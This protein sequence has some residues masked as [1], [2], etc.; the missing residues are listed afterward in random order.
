MLQSIK[1]K[2]EVK[3]ERADIRN[4][5]NE[6]S[7]DRYRQFRILLLEDTEDSLV[8]KIFKFHKV[9][10][11]DSFDCNITIKSKEFTLDKADTKA[12]RKHVRQVFVVNDLGTDEEDIIDY[13]YFVLDVKVLIDNLGKFKEEYLDINDFVA[14]FNES[15]ELLFDSLDLK[16][17]RD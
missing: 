9:N 2:E 7:K 11:L 13:E 5:W 15:K 6:E 1:T 3:L 4:Y 12:L 10:S 17:F 16:I 8:Y 14:L